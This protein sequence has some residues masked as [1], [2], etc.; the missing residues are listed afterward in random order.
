MKTKIL[1]EINALPKW[2]AFIILESWPIIVVIFALIIEFKHIA[3]S[4]WL[5]LFFYNGDSLTLPVLRESLAHKEPFLWVSSSQFL[6]FPEGIFYAISSFLTKSVRGSLVFNAG[7]NMVVLY[8]LFR[9][10]AGIISKST[11]YLKQLF[12]LGSCLLLIFYMLLERHSISINVSSVATLFLFTTYYYGVI[13]AGIFMLCTLL[14]TTK[15]FKSLKE[16]TKSQWALIALTSLV[17]LLSTFSD[18]IFIVQFIVPILIA[19]FIT[20]ICGGI[21]LKQSLIFA[22]P[23]II[24]CIVGYIARAPFKAF[25]GISLGNHVATQQI[26]TTLTVFHDSISYNLKSRSG[27]LELLLI[28]SVLAFSLVYICW[29]VYQK[30]HYKN[31]S[32]DGLLFLL[33]LFSLIEALIVIFFSIAI[34]SMVTRYLLP[35]VIFPMLG[36]LPL[37]NTVEVV[38]VKA[39]FKKVNHIIVYI[40]ILIIVIVLVL[41]ILSI[42]RASYV[43]SDAS[44]TDAKCLS[45]ALDNKPAYGIGSYWT[46]RSLDVYGQSDEQ[47]YQVSSNLL[48][49]VWQTNLGSYKGKNFTFIIVDKQVTTNVRIVPLADPA[50]PANPEKIHNCVDMK[51]Y[52]YKPGSTGYDQINYPIHNSYNN[53]VKLRSA[54][55]ILLSN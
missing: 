53:L 10:V 47:A 6:L 46:V 12:A 30:T 37:L 32:L 17:A 35:M 33:A 38:S 49:F 9:W 14:K 50:I 25:I 51:V 34:G 43:L 54:G 7:L 16:T 31:K 52:V 24:G 39:K 13:I 29:W 2:L 22:I 8:V 23:S 11:R 27:S 40:P 41:G 3:D 42:G 44:Y 36:L 15:D 26:P 5:Q 19:L 18:P 20:Y 28:F 48:P 4:S 45:T 21:R 1:K 55:N